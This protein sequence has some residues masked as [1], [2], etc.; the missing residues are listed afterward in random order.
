MKRCA[1]A[2]KRTEPGP[3]QLS[4]SGSLGGFLGLLGPRSLVRAS[5]RNGTWVQG[6]LGRGCRQLALRLVLLLRWALKAES[7][8]TAADE[9]EAQLLKHKQECPP[10]K[11]FTPPNT[12]RFPCVS[13]NL[14]HL[15]AQ[16]RPFP[17][18]TKGREAGRVASAALPPQQ[19]QGTSLFNPPNLHPTGLPFGL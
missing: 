15:K 14:F 11:N 7:S 13:F 18:R 2:Q 17:G 8:R 5:L 10:F 9:M 12:F 1:V 6:V 16:T 3:C 4:K 19:Q